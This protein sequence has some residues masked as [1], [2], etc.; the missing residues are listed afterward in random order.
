MAVI[1]VS[2]TGHG[3]APE[4]VDQVFK[5]FFSTK[6]HGTGLGLATTHRLITEHGG[7]VKVHS[8]IGRGTLFS[9]LLPGAAGGGA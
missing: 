1:E 8:D 7:K 9:V 6:P 4:N 3:I 2:D 5:P